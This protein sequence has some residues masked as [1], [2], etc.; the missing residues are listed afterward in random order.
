MKKISHQLG[1]LATVLLSLLVPVAR[2][3]VHKMVPRD[4]GYQHDPLGR[5]R[6]VEDSARNASPHTFDHPR[7][8]ILTLAGTRAAEQDSFKTGTRRV[9]DDA[10]PAS[11]PGSGKTNRD[12]R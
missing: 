9:S 8:R 10:P 12:G 1:T 7:P 4:V 5:F 2:R 6:F 11:S 3:R